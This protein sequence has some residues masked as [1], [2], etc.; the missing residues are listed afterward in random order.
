MRSLCVSCCFG[1]YYAVASTVSVPNCAGPFYQLIPLCSYMAAQ[2]VLPPIQLDRHSIQL[3]VLDDATQS[4]FLIP[5]CASCVVVRGWER[6]SATQTGGPYSSRACLFPGVKNYQGSTQDQTA[7]HLYELNDFLA[8][9][10]Y[11]ITTPRTLADQPARCWYIFTHAL[12][13]GLNGPHRIPR[14]LQRRDLCIVILDYLLQPLFH[15][16]PVSIVLVFLDI[17]I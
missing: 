12:A 2:S 3:C 4:I 13:E 6:Y 9:K 8:L 16:L 11:S 14:I 15:T 10:R 5:L 17:Y 1:S 7:D